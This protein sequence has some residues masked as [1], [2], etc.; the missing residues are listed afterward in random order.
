MQNF[1]ESI[2]DI[3]VQPGECIT[4]YDVKALFTSVPAEPALDII[5]HRLTKDQSLTQRTKLKV[6]YIIGLLGFC[7]HSTFFTF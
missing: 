2:K 6:Q 4:S 7:L 3:T 5:S 1:T